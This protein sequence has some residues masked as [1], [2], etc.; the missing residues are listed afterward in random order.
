MYQ[1]FLAK[2]S[3]SSICYH[4]SHYGTIHMR[5][6]TAMP[7]LGLPFFGVAQGTA[8]RSAADVIDPAILVPGAAPAPAPGADKL[9]GA[10]RPARVRHHRAQKPEK[11]AEPAATHVAP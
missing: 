3:Y 5:H 1:K 11:H 2:Q 7:S 8:A 10:S 9:G 6:S 4:P